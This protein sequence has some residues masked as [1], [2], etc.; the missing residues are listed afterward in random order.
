MPVRLKKFIG[1]F[2]ILILMGFY[3][4]VVMTIAVARLMDS[5][6]WV[7]VVYFMVAGMAW[8]LPVMPII[9]WMERPPKNAG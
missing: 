8:A 5:P 6:H 4:L 9:R 3:A 7:Q 2:A 1:L